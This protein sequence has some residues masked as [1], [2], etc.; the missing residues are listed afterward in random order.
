MTICAPGES[1]RVYD[2][3]I[4]TILV[5][6]ALC[7]R[8]QCL[9]CHSVDGSQRAQSLDCEADIHCRYSQSAARLRLE[10]QGNLI[11]SVDHTVPI[12]FIDPTHA[13]NP[14][15]FGSP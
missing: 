10:K 3:S 14:R 11:V 5:M 13:N 9:A 6:H 8:D 15:D 1:G 7:S 2:C 12:P 4:I